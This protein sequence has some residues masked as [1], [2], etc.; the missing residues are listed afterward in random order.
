MPHHKSTAGRRPHT[1]KEPIAELQA[2]HLRVRRLLDQLEKTQDSVTNRRE[3]L[4]A[5][6]E[7]ELKVHTR[8]EE[9]IFYPAFFESARK[10]DD[11]ELYFEAL[12]EHHVVDLVLP[13]IK[14]VDPH[15]D[16]FAAKAKVLKDLVEHHA[17]EEETE[18]FPRARKL[19]PRSDLVRLGEDL[20]RAKA[21]RRA[22]AGNGRR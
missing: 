6:I 1:G 8:I 18:M 10:I 4:L 13:E 15:S 9:E 16:Q 22:V 2:D 17:E 19:M 7:H 11:R 3:K 14:E 20:A 12:E 21:L 5:T